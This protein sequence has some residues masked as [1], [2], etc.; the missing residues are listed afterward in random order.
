VPITV[1]GELNHTQSLRC[2]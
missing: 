2:S 1:D